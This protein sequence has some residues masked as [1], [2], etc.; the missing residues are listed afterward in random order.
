VADIRPILLIVEDDPDI[1]EMLEDYFSDERYHVLTAEEGEIAV[2]ICRSDRPDLILLDIRL[3]DIDGYAVAE[4][5]RTN[6]RTREI[7]IIFLTEKRTKPDRLQ[8]LELGADD[9]LTKPFDIQELGLRVRNA[10]RRT[11][12]GALT[13]PVTRLPNGVLVDERLMACLQDEGWVLLRISLQNLDY[14]REAYGFVASDDVLRAVGLMIQNAI[15]ETGGSDDFV[16]HLDAF[17]FV[18][19]TDPGLVDRLQERILSRVEQSIDYFYPIDKRGQAEGGEKRIKI[20]FGF[21]YANQGP[22]A[23]LSGIKEALWR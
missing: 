5:L 2:E 17:N 22:F 12:Q 9:Y 18:I 16:G 3:P 10:L 14:F 6:Q 23:G 15:T 19:L 13:N 1:S 8:G 20:N 4:K 21:V 11:H 7:P